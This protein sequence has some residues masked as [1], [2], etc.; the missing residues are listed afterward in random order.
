MT[1]II[2]FALDQTWGDMRKLSQQRGETEEL[3][4]E[5]GRKVQEFTKT[6][7]DYDITFLQLQ[8]KEQNATIGGLD[9]VLLLVKRYK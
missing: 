1:L 8:G 4:K 5:G 9:P 3:I 6:L 7:S 2:I